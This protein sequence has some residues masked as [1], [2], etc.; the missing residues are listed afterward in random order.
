VVTDSSA[1]QEE[2]V[3]YYPFGS[4]RLD[5]PSAYFT[6]RNKY[7]GQD[8]DQETGLNY[9]NARYQN[10][11]RGLF[12]SQ[13]PVFQLVG[14]NKFEEK[15]K[16]NWGNIKASNQSA[17]YEYLSNPQNLNSYS[18]SINNPIKFSDPKGE[19]YQFIIGA[20][21]GFLGG[22][23][24]QYVHDVITNTQN[25][26]KGLDIFVPKSSLGDYVKSGGKGTLVGV[27]YA[28]GGPLLAGLS[29]G[30]LSVSD[31]ISNTR[32][33]S[34][35][36]AVNNAILTSAVG[37]ITDAFPQVPGREPG[38]FTEAFFSGRHT[39]NEIVKEG[40]NVGVELIRES[41]SALKKVFTN[42]SKI[43]SH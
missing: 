5:Q 42:K 26:Q 23:A 22:T 6:E 36:G 35:S 40:I 3:D 43:G 15:W 38:L 7:I 28:A 20:G 37:Y 18:Y 24:N 9:L 19:F 29:S 10:G 8:Y 16:N 17:L 27:S 1:V 30:T 32:P 4:P 39:Q 13:D 12:L 2:L 14:S 11:A 25:E 41:A 21:L 34:W 33:V 31:D